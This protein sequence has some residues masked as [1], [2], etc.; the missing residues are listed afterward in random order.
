MIIFLVSCLCTQVKHFAGYCLH[1]NC[2]FLPY[3]H[4]YHFL[5]FMLLFASMT[6][7]S[8]VF[9]MY[10][11]L[12]AVHFNHISSFNLIYVNLIFILTCYSFQKL[13]SLIPTQKILKAFRNINYL[14]PFFSIKGFKEV[15][16]CL[17]LSL[18]TTQFNVLHI[19][20]DSS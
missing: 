11:Q 5:F 6:L 10:L 20:S 17:F 9:L 18:S 2:Y 12:M 3:V 13:L 8:Q 16:G 7:P 4:R 1:V 15:R 14:F 19:T